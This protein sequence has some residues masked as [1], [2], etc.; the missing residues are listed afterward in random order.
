M[1]SKLCFLLRI[2]FAYPSLGFTIRPISS[3]FNVNQYLCVIVP[4]AVNSF[5]K[6]LFVCLW[7][8]KAHV[9]T[10]F[11]LFDQL[12][13]QLYVNFVCTHIYHVAM[14]WNWPWNHEVLSSSPVL[15]ADF[16]KMHIISLNTLKTGSQNKRLINRYVYNSSN[17]GKTEWFP[18]HFCQIGLYLLISLWFVLQFHHCGESWQLI[19]A[20]TC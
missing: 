14:K 19:C 2:R 17:T 1:K 12:S 18:G 13:F 9:I 5:F 10:A 16:V 8:Q 11:S 20:G 15:Q 6:P 3:V 4:H 7:F